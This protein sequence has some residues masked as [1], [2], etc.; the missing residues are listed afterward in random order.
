MDAQG[1]EH[2]DSEP[3][4]RRVPPAPGQRIVVRSGEF[5]GWTITTKH[6]GQREYLILLSKD[7]ESYDDWVED[8]QALIGWFRE[9]GII[10]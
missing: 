10:C 7:A 3:P 1:G 4:P 2:G 6:H 9:A 8:D 5:E